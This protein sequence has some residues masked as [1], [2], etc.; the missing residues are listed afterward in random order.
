ML[1]VEKNLFKN[2]DENKITEDFLI[3]QIEDINYNIIGKK[4]IT[5]CTITVKNGFTFTGEAA[6]VDVSNFNADTGKAISYKNAFDKMWLVY[7]FC[8]AQYLYENR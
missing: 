1:K 8:L 6:C 2:I 5:H 4:K 7:G 3:E